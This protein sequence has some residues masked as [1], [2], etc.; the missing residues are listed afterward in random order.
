MKRFSKLLIFILIGGLLFSA[1]IAKGPEE[2]D[3]TWVNFTETIQ[4]IPTE[5]PS[6]AITPTITLSPSPSPS[7]VLEGPVL[8]LQSGV[9]TYHLIDLSSNGH[10]PYYPPGAGQEHPLSRNLSPSGDYLLFILPDSHQAIITNI[11]SGQTL[12][13]YDLNPFAKDFNLQEVVEEASIALSTTGLSSDTLK[14]Y[15]EETLVESSEDIRWYQNDSYNLLVLDGSE[16]STH[17]FLKDLQTGDQKQLEERPGLV[18]DYWVRN[19]SQQILLKKGYANQPNLW[20]DDRYYILNLINNQV[21]EITL[22]GNIDSP[23]VYWYS[24]TQIGVIHQLTPFGSED[25]SIVDLEN[26]ETTLVEAGPFTSIQS[27]GANQ[28]TIIQD[29]A[30]GTTSLTL[31]M[32]SGEMIATNT[33][34]MLCNYKARISAEQILLNCDDESLLLESPDL[35][36]KSFSDRVSILSRAPDRNKFVLVTDSF[37]T[38]LVDAGLED[39]QRLELDGTPYEIRWLPDGSGFLYR[40]SNQLLYYNLGS[41]TSQLIM[42][43][44]LFAD[45]RNLN[46]IWVNID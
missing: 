19:G 42:T 20:Q 18:E 12:Y 7:P 32:L 15:V 13:T 35:S 40:S 45:Y 33:L 28:L 25:F 6:K 5:T 46:A 14:G 17:L 22:P 1:C 30:A 27:F 10:I 29:R 38:Y 8:L 11:L 43:S 24:D 37:Q 36:V 31:R 9:G 4:P 16:N 26:M 2:T 21:S 41:Q 39:F 3:E 23:S 44:D 34:E